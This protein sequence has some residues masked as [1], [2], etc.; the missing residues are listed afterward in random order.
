MRHSKVLGEP[1]RSCIHEKELDKGHMGDKYG[2]LLLT[3]VGTSKGFED[4]D[5]R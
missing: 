5:P 2:L 3:P 1:N 4:V